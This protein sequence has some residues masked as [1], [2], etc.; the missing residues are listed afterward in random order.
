LAGKE[1]IYPS[2]EKTG[3]IPFRNQNNRLRQLFP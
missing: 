1:P 3:L 2:G